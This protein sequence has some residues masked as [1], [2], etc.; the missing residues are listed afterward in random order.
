MARI[1]DPILDC[2]KTGRAVYGRFLK[3]YR[4]TEW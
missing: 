4:V 1:L 3:D 2:I